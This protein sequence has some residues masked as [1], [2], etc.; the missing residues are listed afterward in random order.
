MLTIYIVDDHPMVTEGIEK[1]L[2]RQNIECHMKAF[3]N[4]EDLLAAAQK[5]MPDMVISDIT[6]PK[7]DGIEMVHELKNNYPRIKVLF[8]TMHQQAWRMNEM[9]KLNPNGVIFKT[10]PSPEFVRAVLEVAAGRTFFSN[11]AKNV[12]VNTTISNSVIKLSRREKEILNLIYQ[13]FTTKEI[14]CALFISTN[15][16]E[17]HR[18]GLF[19]KL[20]VKNSSSLIARAIDLGLIDS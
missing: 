12:I 6:L 16:I 1:T 3:H 4:A 11:E 18:K 9:L 14:A 13:G 8:F 20:D 17:S 15:T 7:M 10:C 2:A 5:Q 19:A